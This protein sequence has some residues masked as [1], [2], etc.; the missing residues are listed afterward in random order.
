MFVALNGPALAT[1]V[2]FVVPSETLLVLV[3]K[4]ERGPRRGG[5]AI[6]S[7][8][9]RYHSHFDVEDFYIIYGL[10][11]VIKQIPGTTNGSTR[12]RGITSTYPV[13]RSMPGATSPVNRWSHS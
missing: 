12:N 3:I 4:D 9:L 1:R 2:G 10:T 6:G 5:G 13:A 8:S 7:D 11:Q